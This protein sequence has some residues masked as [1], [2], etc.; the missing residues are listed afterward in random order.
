MATSTP[1]TART[2]A[3]ARAAE[4]SCSP[5][6]PRPSSPG[7]AR[8]AGRQPSRVRRAMSRR[9]SGPAL[10]WDVVDY[11][12]PHLERTR[13]LLAAHPEVRSLFGRDRSTAFWVVAVVALQ[14][15]LAWVLRGQPWWVVLLA[16]YAVGALADHALWTLI[17]DCTH[18]LVFR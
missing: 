13:E 2:P 10:A 5:A 6:R 7:G 11:P 12:E 8:S 15:A 14:I 18:N 1:S 9:M 3:R 17:H 4:G 16:A